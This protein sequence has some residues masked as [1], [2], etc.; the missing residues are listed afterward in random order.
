MFS[1]RFFLKQAWN[2]SRRYRHL[3]FFGIFASLTAIGGEYQIIAQGM[4]TSPGG[5]FVSTG[6]YLFY[7]LFDPNFYA[8]LREL[9]ISN[10]AAL[11]SLI[12]ALLLVIAIIAVMV[13]LAMTSQAAIIEQSAQIIIGKKKKLNLS[14]GEGLKSGRQHCGHMLA[15]NIA[16]HLFITFSFFIISLPLVFLLI[17][18]DAVLTLIYTILFLIFIPLAL[19][20]ALTIKYALA[21]RV[22]EGKSFVGSIMKGLE[23]FR[24]NWLVS[25]EMAIILFLINFAI[26]IATIA[27]IFLFFLPLFVLS[28]QLY[29]PIL[30]GISLVLMIGTMLV[31]ASVLNTFQISSWT[32][33][34][35][36]LQDKKGRS[37]IERIFGHK[38]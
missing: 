25:L 34:Y 7:N 21:A 22:L 14:I 35:L 20:I 3:W 36:S 32:G 12:S 8:G 15:L 4:N 24:N 19:S 37:K 33:L 9:A 10:P 27:G 13:Y 30:T 18:S 31:V 29:L 38:R 5:S 1:Y 23:I 11:W 2:I 26:G 6:F 17:T 28:L 16:N